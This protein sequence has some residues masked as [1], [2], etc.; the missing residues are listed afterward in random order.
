MM[1][2]FTVGHSNHSIEFFLSLLQKHQITTV[3]DVRSFPYSKYSPHFNQKNIQQSLQEINIS[4]I[5]LGKE[6]GAR[7]ND[8]SCYVNGKALYE[9][10][11]QTEDFKK[12]LERVY[13]SWENHNNI[14][15]MCSEQ[16]PITCH[17]AIL[18]SRNLKNQGLDIYH[19]LKSGELENHSDLEKR[20]LEINNL[21]EKPQ[22]FLQ[23]SL[24]DTESFSQNVTQ[25][26]QDS[27][28]TKLEKAYKI[29]GDKI[30]YVNKK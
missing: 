29:Q 24:F 13:Q 7:T 30:A 19:I 2:L 12:G 18:V 27:E 4:Y 1:K 15:L 28:Y 26:T 8:L 17:R 23:L 6:L 25:S 14:A 20:L 16:D 5:F 22:S 21:V 9:L 11:A 10:I 3:A